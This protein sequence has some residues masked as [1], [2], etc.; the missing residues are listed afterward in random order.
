MHQHFMT[1]K[2]VTREEIATAMDKALSELG[3]IIPNDNAEERG[4]VVD[5]IMRGLYDANAAFKDMNII[6]I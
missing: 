1:H 3:Y 5:S 2:E 6:Q 4:K